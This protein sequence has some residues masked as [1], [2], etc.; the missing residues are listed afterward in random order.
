[1]YYYI[2]KQAEDYLVSRLLHTGFNSSYHQVQ[3]LR[4]NLQ[5]IQLLLTDRKFRSLTNLEYSPL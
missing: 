1:M 4:H 3:Q 5:P 2:S